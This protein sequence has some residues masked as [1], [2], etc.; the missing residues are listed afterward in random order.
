MN[1]F[2]KIKKALGFGRQSKIDQIANVLDMSKW[3]D[4]AL[5]AF[6]KSAE[7]HVGEFTVEQ[8]RMKTDVD[9]PTDGRSWGV[10]TRNAIK[11][12]LIQKTG[13]LAPAIS[14]NRSAKPLYVCMK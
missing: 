3:E 2:N 10:V 11:L 6:I 12:G 13:K 7:S 14:S 9:L 4:R 8:I 1:I 5:V